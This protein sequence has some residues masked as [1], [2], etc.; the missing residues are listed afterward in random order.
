MLVNIPF[1]YLFFFKQY[2]DSPTAVRLK[3]TYK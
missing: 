3:L 2:V 1:T